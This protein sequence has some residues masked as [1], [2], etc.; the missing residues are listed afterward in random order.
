MT[1]PL[2]LALA[3]PMGAGKT[4]IGRLFAARRGVPFVDLDATIG[5]IPAIWAAEGEAGFR[6]RE[7]A[8][9]LV[10]AQGQGVLALGGGTLVDPANR[11]ALADW[12]VVVLMADLPVLQARVGGDPNRPLA[13]D[14]ERLVAERA[15]VWRA[16]GPELRTDGS[17]DDVLS[18]LE[19][20]CV[21]R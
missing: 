21:S 11:A 14:L 18:A 8:A 7:R 17:V 5:D 19:A 6:A 1:E 16:S 9:L 13:R 2:R 12:R 10:A 3:G 20:L 15:P 4:T